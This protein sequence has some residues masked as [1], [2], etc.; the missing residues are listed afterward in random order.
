MS[1]DLSRLVDRAEA[2]LGQVQPLLARLD[3]LLPMASEPDWSA[4]VAFRWRRR[5]TALGSVGTLVPVRHPAA[6][7]LTDL[8]NIDEQ[9]KR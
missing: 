3:Q 4:A 7:S 8:Q 2:L 1:N 6:L 5:Q 9:K